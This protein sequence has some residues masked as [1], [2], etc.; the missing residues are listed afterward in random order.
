[1]TPGDVVTMF[2]A[3]DTLTAPATSIQIA[4]GQAGAQ[5]VRLLVFTIDFASAPT[6]SL[7]IQGSNSI[8]GPWRTLYTSTSTQHDQYADQSGYAFYQAVL[9]SQSAGGACTVIAKAS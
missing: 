8:T 6:D 9:A 1:M 4:P 7:T 2:A 5:Q 3:T